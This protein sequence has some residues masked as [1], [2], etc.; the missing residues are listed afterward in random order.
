MTIIVKTPSVCR[1]QRGSDFWKPSITPCQETHLQAPGRQALIVGKR[2]PGHVHCRP[3]REN[4]NTPAHDHDATRETG[5][6]RVAKDHLF[7]G[8]IRAVD[9]EAPTVGAIS[10]EE[11]KWTRVCSK[12]TFQRLTSEFIMTSSAPQRIYTPS[13]KGTDLVTRQWRQERCSN[14]L[15]DPS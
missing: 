6:M 11:R 3:D 9:V 10:F 14:Q 15:H 12:L 1:K 2:V 5:A 8:G 13:P 4:E 7:F